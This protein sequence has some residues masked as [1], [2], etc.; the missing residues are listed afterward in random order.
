[1]QLPTIGF[2]GA[3]AIV[4]ATV[5]GF[6]Q[7]AGDVPYPLVVS[8]MRLEAC[9]ALRRKFPGRVSA[10][11]SLQECVDRSDWVVIAVWPRRGRRWSGPCAS[12]RSRRSLM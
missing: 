12:A 9:E 3:G 8:D 4:N 5:T 11:A 10:A 2:L 1:M 6:C 7:R